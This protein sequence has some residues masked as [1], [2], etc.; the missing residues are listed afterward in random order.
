MFVASTAIS[1]VLPC[2]YLF[3]NLLSNQKSDSGGFF[4]NM[5]YSFCISISLFIINISFLHYAKTKHTSINRFFWLFGIETL[6]SSTVAAS[7]ITFY[8]FLF[9]FLFDRGICIKTIL[10]DN[11]LTG[12]I[13]NL[14]VMLLYGIVNYFK[15]WKEAISQAEELKRANIE[16]QY[17]TLIN[18]LSPHFMFNS[19][20]TLNALITISPSKAQEFVG[21]FSKVYRFVLDSRDKIVNTLSFELDFLNSYIYLQKIRFG[22]N[23]IIKININD[24]ALQYL[25]PPL[26]LQMLVEN[27]IKHNEISKENPLIIEIQDDG[28][29]LEVKNNLQKRTN[30]EPKSGVGLVNLSKRY[31]IL[32]DLEPSFKVIDQEYV[33][34]IPFIKE[35]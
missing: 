27:A 16:S 2:I 31:S 4:F 5:F 25:L 23:L 30:S 35:E 26:A 24:H 12:V 19:L 3:H 15:Q 7:V 20:N 28:Y 33:V 32:S 17:A 22:E 11:I 6:V 10:Y 14:V 13:V 18:Q 29:Y 1:I 9:K 8:I 34:R 21:Q